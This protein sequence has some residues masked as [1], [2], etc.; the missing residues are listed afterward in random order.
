MPATTKY[1]EL[2][3]TM[4]EVANLV[5]TTLEVHDLTMRSV[6]DDFPNVRRYVERFSKEIE[7]ESAKKGY[8]TF[9][10]VREFMSV[11]VEYAEAYRNFLNKEEEMETVKD[12]SV[13]NLSRPEFSMAVVEL[14]EDKEMSK[15]FFQAAY[16]F[17]RALPNEAHCVELRW[18]TVAKG[19][20]GAD[21][22]RFRKCNI[23]S[24]YFWAFRLDSE[25]CSR[26]CSNVSSQ[27]RYQLDEDKRDL[28]N[29]R[30]RETY[31]SKLEQKRAKE[32]RNKD[33]SI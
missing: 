16:P 25:S 23:C 33:G 17:I 28:Y 20:E 4:F 30:R 31:Q 32:R 21:L 9:L 7:S 29:Q 15:R 13:T 27:R 1:P 14:N 10:M 18:D 2:L 11:I 26:K 19:I 6:L 8:M 24:I 12:T 5:P 22:R 3:K